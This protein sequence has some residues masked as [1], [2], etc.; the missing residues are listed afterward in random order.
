MKRANVGHA[1]NGSGTVHCVLYG[2]RQSFACR[3]AEIRKGTNFFTTLIII[4]EHH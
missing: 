2:Y 3:L 1:N 4:N